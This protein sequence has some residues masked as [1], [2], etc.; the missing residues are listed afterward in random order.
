MKNFKLI[1]EQVKQE[2]MS[3]DQTH[4]NVSQALFQ[5]IEASNTAITIGLEGNWGSGKS[6]VIEFL[7]E[8]LEKENKTLF[9]QFDAWA[10]DGD[11]LRRMFLESLIDKIN[12]DHSEKS[13]DKEKYSSFLDS[14]MDSKEEDKKPKVIKNTTGDAQTPIIKNLKADISGRAKKVEIKTTRSAT[15]LGKC[16][17]ISAF[18]VPIGNLLLSQIGSAG[19]Q[20]LSESTN[21]LGFFFS[22]IELI[23]WLALFGSF[24]ISAP[25]LVLIWW[26]LRKFKDDS[27]NK[28]AFLSSESTEDSTQTIN[29]EGDR[30]SVE[31]ETYFENI[32]TKV[33]GEKDKLYQR[34]VIVIDNLDRVTPEHAKTIW[35][36]LQ[37]F[38]QHRSEDAVQAENKNNPKNWREKVWFIVPFDEHGFKKIWNEDSRQRSSFIE[39]CFQLIIEVPEPIMSGWIAYLRKQI[40]YAV[41][42]GKEILK[43]D[44]EIQSLIE[45][46][47]RYYS[48]LHYSPTPRAINRVLNHIGALERQ[49][50][51]FEG[52]KKTA[53]SLAAKTRYALLRQKFGK[54]TLREK[55]LSSQDPTISY[56]LSDKGE[57]LAALLFGVK[58]ERGLEL[59]LAPIIYLLLLEKDPEKGRLK[60][61]CETH[62][63]GFWQVLRSMNLSEKINN[64]NYNLFIKAV[65][66][67]LSEGEGEKKRSELEPLI[68][69]AKEILFERLGRT[70]DRGSANN[71]INAQ[72]FELVKHLYRCRYLS[73]NDRKSL[74]NKATRL[75]DIAVIEVCTSVSDFS[76]RVLPTIFEFIGFLIDEKFHIEFVYG[77]EPRELEKLSKW[78]LEQKKYELKYPRINK[79]VNEAIYAQLKKLKCSEVL[80]LFSHESELVIRLI[81]AHWDDP[82]ADLFQS[83]DASL[84]VHKYEWAKEEEKKK[85][86]KGFCAS[87]KAHERLD[88]L[89]PENVIEYEG[90]LSLYWQYGDEGIKEGIQKKTSGLSA[91][92][93]K[94]AIDT[95]TPVWKY[96]KTKEDAGKGFQI[97]LN[98]HV[99]DI[100]KTSNSKKAENRFTE[101]LSGL[102]E[103]LLDKEKTLKSWCGIYF[104]EVDSQLNGVEFAAFSAVISPTLRHIS[105]DRNNLNQRLIMW[106]G[107]KKWGHLNW[108]LENVSARQS[109]HREDLEP[110]RDQLKTIF[111]DKKNESEA[112]AVC[113]KLAKRF[114]I[115]LNDQN[116]MGLKSGRGASKMRSHAARG[117]KKKIRR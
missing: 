2:D 92:I 58:R 51:Q 42:E 88:I 49:Y 34:V 75:M 105:L 19:F 50:E 95:K 107:K 109:L 108:Y 43:E 86:V 38:F 16:L 84:D 83:K 59:F 72:M 111:N 81:K 89:K 26:F 64:T 85:I 1:T 8:E 68:L 10:H 69:K 27:K 101:H 25:L 5:V 24:S 97:A 116:L 78:F 32:I 9:F 35:A 56:D 90:S 67:N 55:L 63:E 18:F 102:I 98:A 65:A 82:E 99:I 113:E 12:A 45:E 80:W 114:R 36:T 93:W 40:G 31:F 41:F 13:F 33:V 71:M 91:S 112:R 66:E 39:K 11:P 52:D 6:T 60:T 61:L 117:N 104:A 54:A 47:Q 110:L 30:T 94:S 4:K 37:T 48:A 46:F 53:I 29:D 57:E 20:N 73:Q 96:V 21:E 14:V 15:P 62:Q 22:N 74:E 44:T 7:R 76:S 100:L 87:K 23:G 103:L 79:E 115:E 17:A 70:D 28:W 77:F 3:P 106:L